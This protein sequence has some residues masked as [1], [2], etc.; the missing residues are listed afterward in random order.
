MPNYHSP[1]STCHSI[2]GRTSSSIYLTFRII[3][4]ING[5][6]KKLLPQARKIRGRKDDNKLS[7]ACDE[8]ELTAAAKASKQASEL[9]LDQK[10]DSKDVA[11]SLACRIEA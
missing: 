9:S 7:N 6:K 11:E 1:W 5:L 10:T 2:L 8:L 4:L 3:T